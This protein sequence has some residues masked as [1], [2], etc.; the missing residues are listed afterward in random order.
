MINRLL[1]DPSEV[2]R[3]NAATGVGGRDDEERMLR[4]LFRLDGV[5]H[6]TPEETDE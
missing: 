6:A 4:R 3:E 1:H 2:L 5:G